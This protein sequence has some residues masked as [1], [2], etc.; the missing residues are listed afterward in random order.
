MKSVVLFFPKTG[1]EILKGAIDLP[2]SLI[3][4][5]ATIRDDF[6]VKI[7]DQRV[8]KN[9]ERNLISELGADPLCVGTS[10]MTGGQIGYG[11]EVAGIV[12]NYVSENGTSTKVVWGGIHGTLLPEQTIENENIDVLVVGEGEVTFRELLHALGGGKNLSGIKGVYFKENGRI[13]KN[14]RRDDVC[15][16]DLPVMP[17]DLFDI[18]KYVH[19]KSIV[20]RDVDRVLPFISSRG[21]SHQCT[22]CCNPFLFGQKWRSMSYERTYREVKALVDEYDLDGLVFHD[23]NFLSNP[24]RA[25]KIAGLINNQFSWGIQCRMDSLLNIDLNKLSDMGLKMVHPGIESGSERILRLIKKGETKEVMDLAN[26][27]LAKTDIIP[28]YNFMI[29][30]PSETYDDLMESVD[31]ALKLLS[32][33]ANAEI[34]GFYIFVP[35]PGTEMFKLAVKEGFKPPEDLIGWSRFDRQHNETPWIKD[36]L[37]LLNSLMVSS[38]LLDGKRIE[39]L[40]GIRLLKYPLELFGHYYRNRWR[41]HDFDS[42]LTK[43]FIDFF[44][45][46]T[47]MAI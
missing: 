15:L 45:W 4:V 21:C 37:E 28:N 17:Y 34:A 9:W 47:K 33:N 46:R 5:A 27:A 42:Y 10:S 18:E 40:A 22:Y 41:T 19:S 14:P 30:F 32:D 25:L 24:K 31:F 20:T 23:E 29:G 35:Y 39:R 36:K 44:N 7:I 12:K 3:M 8:D 38:K 16:E 2:L 13:I 1:F 6:N 43:I 26:Q 11:L